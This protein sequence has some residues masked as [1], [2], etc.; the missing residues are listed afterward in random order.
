MNPDVAGRYITSDTLIMCGFAAIFGGKQIFPAELL[1]AMDRDL[2]HRGP[3]AGGRV[4]EPG[5]ALVFRRLSIL[6][7]RDAA[8]QPMTDAAGRYTIVFN[9]EI[10]NFRALRRDLE[11]AGATFRT[12]SDTEV[13]LEG[14]A[15]WG[16]AVFDRLEGMYALAILDRVDQ[17]VTAARDPFGIK[18]LYLTRQGETVAFASE[19]RPLRRLVPTEI[20]PAALTE[21]LVYRFAAGRLSNLRHIELVP[22]GSVV[23]VALATNTVTERRFS[24]VLD[25]LQPDP[26]MTLNDAQ[27]IIAASL[28]ASVDAHLASDVG[29]AL[30]LSGGVDSSLLCAL[31]AQKTSGKL[32]TFGIDLGDVPENERRWR[33]QV[34]QRYDVDHHEVALDDRQFADALPRAVAAMEGPVPHLGCVMLMAL[35]EEIRKTDKVVLTGEGADEMFG[36]YARYGNWPVQR[37]HARFAGLVPGFAWPALGRYRWLKRYAD[38]EPAAIAGVYFDPSRLAAMFPDLVPAPGAPGARDVAAARFGDFRDRML[39]VDQTAY[40]G[41]LLMRQDRMAMATSV[42]ARVPFTHLPLAR[43]VNRITNDLR[44]PGGETKP[45][46]KE[47]AANHLPHDVVY[48][49]KVGLNLPYDNWLRDP[50]GLGRYVDLLEQP[51]CALADWADGAALKTYVRTFRDGGLVRGDVPMIHLVDLELWLRNMREAPE[52]LTSVN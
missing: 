25:L 5:V 2:F 6:D 27:D 39:A 37:R 48:R 4:V 20:D 17:T 19:M 1:D 9:G 46:L 49:R 18:P 7:V 45:L 26:S 50:E 14:F 51:D 29:Y 23:R 36:G 34:T 41:S 11:A 24:D 32:R 22:G 13:I 3:D 31:A 33:D 43:A 21:L 44:I 15:R 40:L 42:E 28:E 47:F 16:E 8:N 38:F 12:T 30:Q 10:Y 35:C 52:P